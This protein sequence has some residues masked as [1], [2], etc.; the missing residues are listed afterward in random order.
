MISYFLN[1]IFFL[2]ILKKLSTSRMNK[3]Y[4]FVLKLENFSFIN[5]KPGLHFFSFQIKKNIY[6]LYCW[7][8]CVK[9]RFFVES[10]FL[11][12]RFI[13][14]YQ[15]HLSI[16]FRSIHSHS[17]VIVE[18]SVVFVAVSA[19]RVYYNIICSKK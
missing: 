16:N 10:Q 9:L 3:S 18:F 17:E 8:L 4:E 19:I 5:K 11:K 2:K 13:Y 1:R 6:Y 15:I 7:T 14:T 12:L